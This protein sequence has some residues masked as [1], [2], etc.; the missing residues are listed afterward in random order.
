MLAQ[1]RSD[2]ERASSRKELRG[3][4]SNGSAWSR[5]KRP[6]E[7]RKQLGRRAANWRSEPT[8][9]QARDVARRKSGFRWLEE[10]RGT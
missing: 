2:V 8:C 5:S 1:A 3:T 6:P 9:E 7:Q 10:R 4:S